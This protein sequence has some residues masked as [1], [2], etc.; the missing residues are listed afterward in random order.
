[1][2]KKFIRLFIKLTL[3]DEIIGFLYW[4]LIIYG[5]FFISDYSLNPT[6][7]GFSLTTYI[8]ISTLLYIYGIKKIQI[9]LRDN[10]G[11]IPN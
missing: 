8:I 4:A 7:L 2:S 10:K 1:M 11:T 6:A 3:L 5:L 9:L